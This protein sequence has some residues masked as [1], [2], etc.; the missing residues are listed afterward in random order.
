[1]GPV[2]NHQKV[3]FSHI[4][5]NDETDGKHCEQRVDSHQNDSTGGAQSCLLAEI[6]EQE[7]EQGDRQ[8]E[9]KMKRN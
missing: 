1:M 3:G 5:E 2:L 6:E 9:A 8:R 7:L 4:V